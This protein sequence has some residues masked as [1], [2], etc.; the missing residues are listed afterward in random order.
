MTSKTSIFSRARRKNNG[1]PDRQ[2]ETHKK[3]IIHFTEIQFSPVLPSSA[4]FSRVF[5]SFH[6][7]CRVFLLISS[8]ST[9]FRPVL[10]S[11]LQ[12]SPVLSFPQFCPISRT[13]FQ[14]SF[15]ATSYSDTHTHRSFQ[16][17]E[18][19][20]TLMNHSTKTTP[21][22]CKILYITK[23]EK[24]QHL[25]TTES[26]FEKHSCLTTTQCA[27]FVNRSIYCYIGIIFRILANVVCRKLCN[28][29]C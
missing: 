6:Q 5:P 11:F 19:A 2:E 13:S 21:G 29:C 8:S 22:T 9:Q 26:R 1:P 20:T 27:L 25:Y 23:R 16:M 24:P 15:F 3:Y 4:Q 14:F 18:V 10:P 12:F 7:F 17:L 28:W